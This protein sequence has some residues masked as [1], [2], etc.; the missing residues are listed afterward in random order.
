MHALRVLRHLTERT[1]LLEN[2]GKSTGKADQNS[3]LFTA[4][5]L[6]AELHA[7]IKSKVNNE[8]AY[9]LTYAIAHNRAALVNALETFHD[10]A[11]ARC[12]DG[13]PN[14]VP[15]M[16]AMF[17]MLHLQHRVLR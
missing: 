11:K 3:P 12:F 5:L 16:G 17:G 7:N 2:Y 14:K 10:V 4:N 8:L 9:P 13:Q 1:N 15:D 6:E